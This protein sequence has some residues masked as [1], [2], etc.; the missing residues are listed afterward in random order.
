MIESALRLGLTLG[1]A[2]ASDADHVCTIASLLRSERGV[3]DALKTSLVWGLGHSA[4]FFGVGLLLVAAGLH[5]PG[6]MAPLAEAL[7][8]ASLVWL[9]VNQWRHAACPAVHEPRHDGRTFALGLVHGLAGS[10]GVGLLALSTME[11]RARALAFLVLYGAGVVLG[12]AAVTLALALP[13][14]AAAR[15]STAWRTGVLRVA[16]TLSVGAGLWLGARLV[17]SP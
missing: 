1:L 10:A 2:H 4:T 3:R 14:G 15:R 12:M 5:L 16:A 11:G 8:A 7:V 17:V 9:G 6:W 13:L